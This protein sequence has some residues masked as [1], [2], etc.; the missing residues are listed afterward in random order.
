MLKN[1]FKIAYRNL[2]KN[3][4]FSF[5][6]VVGLGI[7]FPFALLS[8]IQLQ[9]SYEFDNWHEDRDRIFRVITDKMDEHGSEINYASS[10]FLLEHELKNTFPGVEKSTKVVR[11]F[12]WS[13]SNRLKTDDVSS[14]YVE[15]SFFEI[16][17]FPLEKGQLPLEPNTLVLS[18]E[19][20]EWFFGDTDPVG[21]SLHHPTY[22]EFKVKGVLKAN[23]PKTQFKSD[24]MISM[25]SFDRIHPSAVHSDSWTDLNSHT[26]VKLSPHV[27]AASLASNL[28]GF[29]KD[30]TTN[31]TH[32]KG[33]DLNFRLQSLEDVSPAI[34]RLEFN[35]YV[36]DLQDIYFNFSIPLMILLLAGFNYINLTLA[37]SLNRSKEVGVRKVMGALKK[38][39]IFQFLAESVLVSVLALALGL[40]ILW[41]MKMHVHVQWITWEVDNVYI[42]FLLVGVFTVLLGLLAGLIPSF[43]MSKFQAAKVLKGD[44]GPVGFGKVGFRRVLSV[45]QFTVTMAFIFQIGHLYNQF[46]YMATENDS[47]DRKGQYNLSLKDGQEKAIYNDLSRLNEIENIGYTSQIFGNMPANIALTAD[48]SEGSHNSFYYAVD[49]GFIENMDLKFLAGENLPFSKSDSA[50]NLVII[51]ETAVRKL[52]LGSAS[53][54]IGKQLIMADDQRV[55][56]IGV[57]KDFCNFN[58]QLELQ[59][60]VMQYNPG[61]F[62]AMNIKTAGVKDR[63]AFE[64]QLM[65]VWKQEH[66]FEE[67]Y[68]TWLD[69][70]LYERYYPAEDMK[71][72]GMASMVIFMIAIMG[73]LGIL[74]YTNERRIKEIGIRK[75]MGAQIAEIVKMMSWSFIKL[76]LIATLIAVPFGVF[77]GFFMSEYLFKFNNGINFLYMINI[78]FT[79][80]G[81]ALAM[82]VYASYKSSVVNPVKSL[83]SE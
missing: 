36:E 3:K 54:S 22:G 57:V 4:L 74:T 59:P 34:E 30:I 33:S 77:A 10:P 9:S 45:I 52:R 63:D 47:F 42:I 48:Q 27:S 67:A 38:Q 66:P 32:K 19:Q 1:Y 35:P 58:Y 26:F 69:T 24:V 70:Q 21:K 55:Q 83:R 65:A 20:A 71:I 75:V 7:A 50:G 80:I 62:A 29:S 37:R 43:I 13:L 72:M 79:V 12:N 46:N 15:P 49:R 28:A 64:S 60:L 44:V 23:K 8:L 56:V 82:V 39:L 68:G 17:D 18:H 51:N 2:L 76:L 73:L 41:Q 5:I 25:A 6:N 31:F 53:E 16:F 61:M 78:V 14:L 81:I 11:E 40:L